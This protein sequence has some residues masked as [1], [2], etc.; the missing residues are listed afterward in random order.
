MKLP[1]IELQTK[2]KSSLKNTDQKI[3][4]LKAIYRALPNM[5]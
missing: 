3:K 2:K 4:T 5:Q 1:G